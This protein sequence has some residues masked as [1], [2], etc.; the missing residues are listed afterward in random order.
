MEIEK[1][2]SWVACV[3]VVSGIAMLGHKNKYGFL[4]IAVGG[5]ITGIL[6]YIAN[7]PGLVLQNFIATVVNIYSFCKWK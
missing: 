4:V 2:F 5:A 7:L 3:L 1:V 6:V